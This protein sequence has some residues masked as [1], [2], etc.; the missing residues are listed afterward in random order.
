MSAGCSEL[1]HTSPFG[2]SA[3]GS[4][5]RSVA[6][7]DTGP[8]DDGDDAPLTGTAVGGFPSAGSGTGERGTTIPPSFSYTGGRDEGDETSGEV[9]PRESMPLIRSFEERGR[10]PQRAERCWRITA[11]A[12]P[13]WGSSAVGRR[14]PGGDTPVHDECD[15][16]P[17]KGGPCAGSL[18]YGEFLVQVAR[19]YK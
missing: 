13:V 7:V 1:T 17:E 15:E 3:T 11:V 2:I 6:D 14:A 9:V 18:E 5:R 8:H 12:K 10:A 19:V 16:S 4:R